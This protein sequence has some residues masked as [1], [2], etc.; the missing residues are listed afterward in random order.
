MVNEV[1]KHKVVGIS[2][3]SKKTIT[4]C[5]GCRSQQNFWQF[6]LKGNFLAVE[7]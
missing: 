7:L 4:H 3:F 2:H 5:K 1:G 6:T